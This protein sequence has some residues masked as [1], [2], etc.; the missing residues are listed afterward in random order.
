MSDLDQP[1][2]VASMANGKC[3]VL[4]GREL[5]LYDINS[6]SELLQLKGIN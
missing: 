6:A 5:R 2:R 3:V 4:C 1:L